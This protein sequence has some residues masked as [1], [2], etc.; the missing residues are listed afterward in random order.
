MASHLR[1]FSVLVSVFFLCLSLNSCGNSPTRYNPAAPA[2]S[3]G[4]VVTATGN[5][6][7]GLGWPNAA[8]ADGYNIY[9]STSPGVNKSNGT[10]F[11]STR[12]KST[13]VTGLTNNT[14]YY[15]V[16]TSVNGTSESAESNVVSA[17][18]AVPGPFS[19]SDLEGKWNFNILVSGATPGWMRGILSISN[20]GNIPGIVTYTNF[21]GSSNY[22]TLPAGIFTALQWDSANKV[23]DTSGKFNGFISGNL[24]RDMIVMTSTFNA[25]SSMIVILQKQ[26]PNITFD[27]PGDLQGSLGGGSNFNARSFV[28][29]QISAGSVQ[30]WEFAL[31]RINAQL[32]V[33]VITI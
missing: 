7:I 26:I 8:D 20:A 14:T 23:R 19:Q 33:L 18:P 3:T 30:E 6:Q 27:N 28:Y 21:A 17:T 9:Y 1:N 22:P 32:Q 11:A 15:F 31:G 25:S 12:S 10:K 5:G 13:I 29:N 2:P 16:F 24:Y 4:L